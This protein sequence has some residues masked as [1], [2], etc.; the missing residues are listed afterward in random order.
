MNFLHITLIFLVSKYKQ[1]IK[2]L[3]GSQLIDKI[4]E[5]EKSGIYQ[6]TS[7]DCVQV[8]IG[9][10]KRKLNTRYQYVDKSAIASC[11]QSESQN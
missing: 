4:P 7:K 6:I 1:N 3:S 9:I 8:Y 11:V 5:E 10:T 2:S